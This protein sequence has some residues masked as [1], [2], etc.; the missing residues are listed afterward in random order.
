MGSRITIVAL[1]TVLC[2]ACGD[3]P[4]EAGKSGGLVIGGD[5]AAEHTARLYGMPTPNE[6]FDVMS[7]MVGEG[8]RRLL[9]PVTNLDHYASLQARALNF[10]VFATDMV[11]AS[12]F[13]LRSEVARY[14]MA[15][16]KLGDQLGISGTFVDTDFQRLERNISQGGDSLAIVGN[17]VYY[18]AYS[19]LRDE[20][21]GPVLTLVI[22]GAWVES[23]HLVLAQ[24]RDADP[25]DPMMRRVAEQKVS[26]EHLL[27]MMGTVGNA[28]EMDGIRRSLQDLLVIFDRV[29]VQRSV[30]EGPSSS[31]RM[32]LGDDVQ[33]TMRTEDFKDLA[34]A[35]ETL[36]A[37]IIRSEE[38]PA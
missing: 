4:E 27:E 24:V 28:R 25:A 33:M 16:R 21:K 13:N 37:S 31:G 35:I 19:R 38:K 11:Y 14:Y 10:G 36:R 15:S 22:A 7:S 20:D 32:I 34:A 2:S 26:L 23:M 1:V 3:P 9:A 30:H 29:H 12:N 17:E 18:K 5:D 6:L 8:H